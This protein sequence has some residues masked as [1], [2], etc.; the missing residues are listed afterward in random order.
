[1]KGTSHIVRLLWPFPA[2]SVAIARVITPWM[3]RA[4]IVEA[5]ALV[6]AVGAVAVL[7]ADI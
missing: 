3:R 1:M 4:R 2:N 7:F 5:A 6:W